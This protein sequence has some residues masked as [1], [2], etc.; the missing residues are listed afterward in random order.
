[1]LLG[2]QNSPTVKVPDPSSPIGFRTE[3]DLNYKNQLEIEKQ[4]EAAKLKENEVALGKSERLNTVMKTIENQW[5]K[6]SP[7]RGAIN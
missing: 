6:T 7:Y 2:N 3:I 1:M 4:A 5:L